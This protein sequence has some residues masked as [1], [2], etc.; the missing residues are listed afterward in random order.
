MQLNHNIKKKCQVFLPT[1]KGD[2]LCVLLVNPSTCM[3]IA[4]VYKISEVVGKM[5]LA[6]LSRRCLCGASGITQK[7]K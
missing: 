6:E 2:V 3:H 5:D 1:E 7:D 4:A